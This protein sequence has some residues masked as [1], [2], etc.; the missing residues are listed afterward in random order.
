MRQSAQKFYMKNQAQRS[1]Y[2]PKFTHQ[3]ESRSVAQARGQWRDLGSL[4]PL[5]T[6]FKQFFCVS[7]LSSWDYR[8][9][10]PR[11]AN[12]CV[13]SRN[14]FQ[15]STGSLGMC[16]SWSLGL[17][18]GLECSGTIL[19]YSNLRLPGSSDSRASASR[20]A[21]ITGMGHHAQLMQHR[22]GPGAVAHAC[23][24]SPL[25]GRAL[26][27]GKSKINVP[28]DL[29]SGEDSLSG[30]QMGSPLLIVSSHGG[31]R[32]LSLALSPRLECSGVISAHCNLRLPDSSNSPVSAFGVAGITGTH[33]HAWLIFILL[34]EMGFHHVGQAILKLLTSERGSRYV[35]QSGLE[36][37]GSSSHLALASKSAAIIV[38]LLSPRLECNGV[39][40]TL[41]PLLP[42]FKR[43]FCLSLLSSWDYRCPMPH[44]ANCSNTGAPFCFGSKTIQVVRHRHPS[45]DFLQITENKPCPSPTQTNNQ[46]LAS[47][48]CSPR[49]FEAKFRSCCLGWSSVAQSWL[50]TT[51]ASRVQLLG[52]MRQ[53]N[54]L[55]PEG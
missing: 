32:V 18:L 34:V 24:P 44:L 26:E 40:S 37:L 35:V 23:N 31:Q 13:F 1:S 48:C 20:I 16:P 4:Q 29:V 28:A 41:Q 15:A 46:R 51:S 36:P 43:F 39:I 14:E 42:R 7:L 27:T 54:L 49:T 21:G 22:K 6:R 12:F 10:P 9:V 2:L 38:S 55:N 8:H 30:L 25:G 11:P 52:R 45:L 5:P 33:H 17:S 19:A 47:S 50:T 53:E 3:M